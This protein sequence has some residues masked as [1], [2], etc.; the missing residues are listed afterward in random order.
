MNE[1][2]LRFNQVKILVKIVSTILTQLDKYCFLNLKLKYSYFIIKR[3]M[4]SLT[5]VR[6]GARPFGRKQ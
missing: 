4:N 6:L 1:L 5:P 2:S 3:F